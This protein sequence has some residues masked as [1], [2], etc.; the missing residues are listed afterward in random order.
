M[1]VKSEEKEDILA[2]IKS[3]KNSKDAL[4]RMKLNQF[5]II[6]NL[7]EELLEEIFEE[8]PPCEIEGMFE[9]FELGNISFN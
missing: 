1:Y 4:F 5:L 6:I 3:L 2:V 9:E 7:D 8:I